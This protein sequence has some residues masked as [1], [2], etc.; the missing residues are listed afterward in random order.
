ME[1]LEQEPNPFFVRSSGRDQSMGGSIGVNNKWIG[2]R[3]IRLD[4]AA[5]GVGGLG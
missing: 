2:E 3:A 5:E 1:I 4:V